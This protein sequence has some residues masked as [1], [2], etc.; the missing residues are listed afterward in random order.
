MLFLMC[1]KLLLEIHLLVQKR[2]ESLEQKLELKAHLTDCITQQGANCKQIF[3]TT[4]VSEYNNRA[5]VSPQ[6]FCKVYNP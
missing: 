2:H 1:Y 6:V 4:L 5:A 3:M